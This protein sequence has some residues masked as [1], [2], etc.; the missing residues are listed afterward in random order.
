MAAAR[1]VLP[2][3]NA[4]GTLQQR[5]LHASASV[6]IH[7]V[8]CRP[9]DHAHG[10]EE[11]CTANQIVFPRS[12]LFVRDARGQSALGNP[13]HVLFFQKHE[14]YRVAHPAGHGDDCTVFCFADATLSEALTTLDPSAAERPEQPFAFNQS[15]SEPRVFLLQE[16]LRQ[17]ADNPQTER[18]ALDEA[19][20]TLLDAVLESAYRKRGVQRTTPS[21]HLHQEQAERT[22]LLLAAHFS[23]DLT[24]DQVAHAVH[25]SPFHL[26]RLF[27]RQTGLS[28]HQYRHQLRLSAALERVVAGERNLSALALQ[29]GFSSHAHLSDAFQRSFGLAPSA[30]RKSLN[31]ARLREMSRILKVAAPFSP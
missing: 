1:D 2:E 10:P 23:E 5:R 30:C 20:L 3:G 8:R 25:C 16:R 29:L 13:N 17:A 4:A 9:H 12:G 18:L 7:D 22:K 6:T 31:T 24:L 19:A 21:S 27:R 15:A 14:V 26:A 11:W 28:V